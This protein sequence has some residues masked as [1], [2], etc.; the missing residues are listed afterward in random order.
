[1][2]GRTRDGPLTARIHNP[3]TQL[4]AGRRRVN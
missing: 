3:I 4:Q 1:M 2:K